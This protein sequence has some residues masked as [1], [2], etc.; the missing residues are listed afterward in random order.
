MT[1]TP[2]TCDALSKRFDVFLALF[3]SGIFPEFVC[4]SGDGQ[5]R[6]YGDT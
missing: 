4:A 3:L 1:F 6:P 2:K 5:R